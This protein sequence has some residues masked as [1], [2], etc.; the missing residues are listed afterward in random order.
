[1]TGTYSEIL[2]E[3]KAKNAEQEVAFEK[4]D[5]E[6]AKA[7]DAV[8]AGLEKDLAES[9]AKEKEIEDLRSKNAARSQFL[10]QPANRVPFGGTP[11]DQEK[12]NVKKGNRIDHV[13][14]MPDPKAIF[15]GDDGFYHAVKVA[16]IRGHSDRE[17]G[18]KA[19]GDW[20]E[21]QRKAPLGMFEGGDSDGGVLVPPDISNRIYERSVADYS[22]LADADVLPIRG[23]TMN[24]PRLD[25]A[26]RANGSRFG[27]VQSYWASEAGS[28]TSS[29]PKF[30][31]LSLRLHKLTV[32]TYLTSE[33]VEDSPYAV[34]T[35]VGNL[36]AKEIRF[37]CND[38]MVNGTGA[39]QPEGI[40]VSKGR[41]T[42]SKETGQAAASLYVDNI[43]KMWMRLDPAFRSESVWLYNNDCTAQLN[44]M[45][46]PVGTGGVPI[47]QPQGGVSN[48][49]FATLK[50][51]PMIAAE[52]CQ[53]LGTEGDIILVH[54][55]SYQ[56]I[57]KGG[58][59]T[60]MS[61]H[62][63]FLTDELA[64]RWT[65]RMDG[66]LKWDKPLTPY[67]GTTTTSPV[68]TLATR[69]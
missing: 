34:A 51:R 13:D 64:Y 60:A 54:W 27:G 40:T 37:K 43:E 29:R 2:A 63:A 47:F 3:F 66:Q 57:T 67:K 53:T 9:K 49:S 5:A 68:V 32:L 33:L 12:D 44:L 25:D 15:K 41:V 35:Y 16:E 38:A 21:M 11:S 26:S 42:V 56:A 23:S 28:F 31:D 52:F 18:L 8:L 45:A 55:P 61:M 36:A 17:W 22:F 14:Q 6:T 65:F 62:V 46:F 10:A 24:L 58:V 59:N 69:S 50:G 48:P 4:G 1:M 39:G 30:G 19:L 20:R 7:L